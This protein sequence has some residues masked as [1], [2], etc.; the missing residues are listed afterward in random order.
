[1]LAGII[2]STRSPI[3]FKNCSNSNSP[4]DPATD[5][6]TFHNQFACTVGCVRPRQ[7]GKHCVHCQFR[8]INQKTT[9]AD[10]KPGTKAKILQ[11]NTSPLAGQL[12]DTINTGMSGLRMSHNHKNREKNRSGRIVENIANQP[13]SSAI[14]YRLINDPHTVNRAQVCWPGDHQ[15][16]VAF[17]F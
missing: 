4:L 11:K 6:L 13:T 5:F 12:V 7:T 17:F 15:L 16:L 9:F 10:T 2:D 14:T 1:M 3:Q 8:A